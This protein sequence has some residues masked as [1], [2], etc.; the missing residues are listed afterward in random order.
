MRAGSRYLVVLTTIAASGLA[1]GAANAATVNFGCN[2]GSRTIAATA[3]YSAPNA[4]QWFVDMIDYS[5]TNSGGGKTDST[6][7]VFN[8]RN[9][10]AWTWRTPDDRGNQSYTKQVNETISRGQDARA[11]QST[12]F[13]QLGPDPSC[14]ND[15]NF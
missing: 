10:A 12:H 9:A 11:H 15:G 2:S 14:T 1:A 6:F 5:Y 13:D 3:F 7:T 4:S 8:G